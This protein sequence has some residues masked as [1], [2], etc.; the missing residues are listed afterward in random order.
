VLK[1]KALNFIIEFVDEKSNI[2]LRA[3]TDISKAERRQSLSKKKNRILFISN[4]YSK[5][6]LFAKNWN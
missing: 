2:N 5:S 4:Y 1:N 3:M 6:K